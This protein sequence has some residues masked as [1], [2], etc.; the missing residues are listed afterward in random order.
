MPNW[1]D[2]HGAILERTYAETVGLPFIDIPSGVW[3]QMTKSIV[4]AKNA[5]REN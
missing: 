2:S 4:E 1:T 5:E 3:R